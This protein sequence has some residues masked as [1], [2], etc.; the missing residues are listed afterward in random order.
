MRLQD[1]PTI[2]EMHRRGKPA[3][4]VD[5]A[6]DV[7][8]AT[9]EPQANPVSHLAA[10]ASEDFGALVP[11]ARRGKRRTI[12]GQDIDD[13]NGQQEGEGEPD[14]TGLLGQATKIA[15]DRI[16]VADGG[17]ACRANRL[18]KARGLLLIPPASRL[19]PGMAAKRMF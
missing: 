7:A 17:G 16:K 4:P 6:D 13:W 12:S 19:I 8:A 10:P 5:V 3:E 14:Q 18:S 2:G 9:D 15:G 1:L 11:D